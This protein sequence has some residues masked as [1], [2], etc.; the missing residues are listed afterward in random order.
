MASAVY[1][2]PSSCEVLLFVIDATHTSRKEHIT[3]QMQILACNS[4]PLNGHRPNMSFSSNQSD[5]QGR[6]VIA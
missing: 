1:L 5:F 2:G 6:R 3:A 4:I